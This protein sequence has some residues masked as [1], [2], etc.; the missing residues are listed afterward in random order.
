M[1]NVTIHVLRHTAAS[2]LVSLGTPITDVSAI[3]GH[4]SS[5]MT[6]DIYGHSYPSQGSSWMQKLGEHIAS[7]GGK[8]S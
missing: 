7:E 5:K 3:L 4:A 2:L 6:L 8:G 1:T